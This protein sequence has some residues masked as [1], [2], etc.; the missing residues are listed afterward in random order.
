[1]NLTSSNGGFASG[2]NI[3]IILDGAALTHTTAAVIN[4][5]NGY[6][7]FLTM[8]NGSS[9]TNTGSSADRLASAAIAQYRSGNAGFIAIS[10]GGGA[11]SSIVSTEGHGAA[12]RGSGVGTHSSISGVTVRSTNGNA[13]YADIQ[14]YTFTSASLISTNS[15][16]TVGCAKSTFNSC[17]VSGTHGIY[18]SSSN[19]NIATCT[20]NGGT[21]T[22]TAGYAVYQATLGNGLSSYTINNAILNGTSGAFYHGGSTVNGHTET[23]FYNCT[24]NVTGGGTAAASFP[25]GSGAGNL[26]Y[27]QRIVS[28]KKLVTDAY[29]I[30]AEGIKTLR[31]E[32]DILIL[33]THYYDLTKLGLG[34]YEPT[35]NLHNVGT[36]ILDG[37]TTLPLLATGL[38]A[39][40]TSGQVQVMVVDSGGLVSR[41][42]MVV[43][44][45]DTEAATGGVAAGETYMTSAGKIRVRLT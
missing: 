30:S 42:A 1:V 35:A 5:Q 18:E 13:V 22:G 21:I 38:T 37:A 7:V 31:K 23:K 3:Y 14:P 36:S 15:Q 40:T 11:G 28:N 26:A 27:F 9:I 12:F 24:L 39:P 33:D 34:I 41:L 20:I 6:Q 43:A 44:A 2:T 25:A 16:G 19:A 10:S 32:N 17:A 4:V 45:D 8:M 29:R